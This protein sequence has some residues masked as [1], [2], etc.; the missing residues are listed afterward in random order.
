MKNSLIVVSPKR[1][2]LILIVVALSLLAVVSAV[3]GLN[4]ALPS[5]ARDTGATQ[6]QLQ[7]IVDAYTTV[8]AGLLLVSGAIGDRF[9]RKWI[10]LVGLIIFGS[11]SAVAFGTTSPVSLIAIRAV[12]G[13][14]AAFIMPTTLSIISTSFPPEE[15]GQAIGVW[16]GIAGGGA[17][18][19]M[20]AS[21]VLLQY[22]TWSSFF[23]LNVG[24]AALGVIGTLAV[25]PHMPE[26]HPPKLDVLGA[27]LSLVG[28]SALIFGIIEGG[29]RGWTDVYVLSGIIGG[30]LALTLFVFWELRIKEPMLDPRLF[31][32]RGFGTGSLSITMQFFASFG[33]FYIALQ[34][35]QYIA[36]FSALHA[37]VTLLPLPIVLIPLAR[38]APALAKRFGTKRIV[39]IGLIFSTA[40]L[41][42]FSRIGVDFSYAVFILGLVFFAIGMALVGT[43]STTA[44]TSSLP[45]EKQGVASAV[46]DVS[47]EF[48]SALGIAIL[49]SVLNDQYKNGLVE[50]VKGL[51]QVVGDSAQ[52]SIVYVQQ[53]PLQKF[54]A[55]GENLLKAANQSFVD[56]ARSAFEVAAVVTILAAIYVVVRAPGKDHVE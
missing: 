20:L 46:N 54:G 40:G 27:L 51:P 26:L 10:L 29:D 13:L 9:G 4:V 24:L 11:A 23:G 50:A 47:R 12:M 21:G 48:G 33:F 30:L 56:A 22:Y 2:I 38:R 18:L 45:H 5:I 17:V 52:K 43:P 55:A 6:S 16:V 25:I 8:F 34:Y 28:V 19:G 53:L 15:R 7:W 49:G 37:A 42:V 31:I 41:L 36:G 32:L 44:I 3:S 35:L 39:T 1:R 14:G